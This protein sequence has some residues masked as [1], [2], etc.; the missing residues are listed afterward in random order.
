MESKVA[1]SPM[2]VLIW[3]RISI[4]FRSR[5]DK[6]WY[7]IFSSELREVVS[8][9]IL[10][11]FHM[12][13]NCYPRGLLQAPKSSSTMAEGL[14]PSLYPLSRTTIQIPVNFFIQITL[15][16]FVLNLLVLFTQQDYSCMI[17]VLIFS[18]YNDFWWTLWVHRPR[19]SFQWLCA[20]GR[21]GA[22]WMIGH[23]REWWGAQWMIRRRRAHNE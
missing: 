6:S 16:F 15:W 2:R 10:D 20:E 8:L 12:N 5:S 9:S 4:F 22:Q 13:L 19:C 11:F 1:M 17:C 23:K 3:S 7:L 14:S 18:F 21:L